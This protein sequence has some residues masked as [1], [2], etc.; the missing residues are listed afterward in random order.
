V[1]PDA[2][3][4]I[5]T[6]RKRELKDRLDR[7]LDVYLEGALEQPAFAAKQGELRAE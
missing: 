4:Q 1:T 2:S 3:R 6:T 7:L 5:L